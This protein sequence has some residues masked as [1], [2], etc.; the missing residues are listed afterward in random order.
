MGFT[1]PTSDVTAANYRPHPGRVFLG[2]GGFRR[3]PAELFPVA[4][5]NTVGPRK[6]PFGD[7]NGDGL[8][9]M[10]IAGHGWGAEPYCGRA[11]S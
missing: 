2:D 8:P 9:D 10:F 3:A 11:R 7:L 5:L 1:H 6:A 4:M